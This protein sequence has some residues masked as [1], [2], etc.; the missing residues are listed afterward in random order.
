VNELMSPVAF[1]WFLTLITGVIA[2]T[3][4]LYDA[5]KLWRLRNADKTDPT[6]RDKIF[7]YS[8]GVLIGGTGVTGCLLFHDVM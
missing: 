3:W 1:K 2:G 6:V 8:M 5:L 7:G 4:F